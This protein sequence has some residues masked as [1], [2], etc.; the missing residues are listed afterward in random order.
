MSPKPLSRLTGQGIKIA[1]NTGFDRAITTL[2]L[3]ATGW[4]LRDTVQA[5]V[6][7][8]DVPQGRPAPYLIFHAMESLGVT[9]VHRT[10]VVGDTVL[11]LQ[12]GWNAGVRWNI[13]CGQGR[14]PAS[15]WNRPRIPRSCQAWR[16][17]RLLAPWPE[18]RRVEKGTGI[19]GRMNSIVRKNAFPTDFT[20][21]RVLVRWG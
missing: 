10:A 6:C 5:V 18:S 9:D 20:V 3:Q 19:W 12:A 2:V 1:I 21:E 7:G 8:D 11:D 15:S 14:T 4:D 16:T 17:C 13:G